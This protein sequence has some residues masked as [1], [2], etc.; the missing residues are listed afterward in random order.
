MADT[1]SRYQED[2]LDHP[3]AGVRNIVNTSETYVIVQVKNGIQ[4]R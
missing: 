1:L 3:E 2:V 4:K